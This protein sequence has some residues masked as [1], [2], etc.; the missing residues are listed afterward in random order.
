MIS[1]INFENVQ[2]KVI[3]PMINSAVH[4]LGSNIG[5]TFESVNSNIFTLIFL[6]LF[7][8]KILMWA[9]ISGF[10]HYLSREAQMRRLVSAFYDPPTESH[11]QTGYPWVCLPARD[12][13][14]IC[15]APGIFIYF[16]NTPRPY[17][18]RLV[19][20]PVKQPVYW[21]GK[22]I[23]DFRS[24][25]EIHNED[26]FTHL[27]NTLIVCYMKFPCN[28]E[29]YDSRP[30]FSEVTLLTMFATIEKSILGVK[31]SDILVF[32]DHGNPFDILRTFLGVNIN[33]PFGT[34]IPLIQADGTPKFG[35]DHMVEATLK[36]L[37]PP[38]INVIN[39]TK[40]I[41]PLGI[42]Y[43]G[44][45]L[46][47]GDYSNF[48]QEESING[49][50]KPCNRKKE[51]EENKSNPIKFKNAP[52]SYRSEIGI[53][54]SNLE[55]QY[56]KENGLLGKS[57][58]E[59][60]KPSKP[61]N[62]G[63]FTRLGRRVKGLFVPEKKS[64]SLPGKFKDSDIEMVELHPGEEQISDAAGVE[65]SQ[66]RYRGTN[67]FFELGEAAEEAAMIISKVVWSLLIYFSMLLLKFF[68]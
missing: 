1:N 3:P 32:D 20:H 58:V 12:K 35:Y 4:T 53:K 62:V 65:H 39:D 2:V 13:N 25:A 26:D 31:D 40:S 30:S 21:I 56:V 27:L 48:G 67:H 54:F 9:L 50:C 43:E 66:I 15:Q 29:S 19:Y 59:M 7:N 51:S 5:N 41:F 57:L 47:D 42:L 28:D 46:L 55:Y 49:V 38:S 8:G 36:P 16:L 18:P 22:S 33:N 10:F 63:L 24:R 60:E 61:L 11:P 52:L 45:K 14:Q 44:G 64:N 23:N 34:S 6:S 17:P 37:A 68:F